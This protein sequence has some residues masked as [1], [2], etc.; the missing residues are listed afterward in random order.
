M[1]IALLTDGI[2]PHVMGGMQKHSYY[3]CKY[4]AAQGVQIDLYHTTKGTD[5]PAVHLVDFTEKERAQVRSF[6]IDYPKSDRLPGHYLRTSYQYSKRIFETMLAQDQLPDFIYAQGL[7]SWHLLR[8]RK[9]LGSIPVGVNIHGYNMYQRP[10]DIRAQLEQY[11]LRPS[12]RFI[13]RN[14]D[15]V[16]AFGGEIRDIAVNRVGVQEERIFEIPNGI[17]DDWLVSKKS[18]LVGPK[19]RR[20]TYVGRYERCKGIE[21]LSAVIE[22]LLKR[23]L[24][25]EF[26]FVGPIP[27]SLHVSHP[28]VNY[29]GK[30]VDANAVKRILRGSDVLILP[31][32]SEGMPT[33]IL[34]AMASGCAVIATDVGA[35]SV[36]VDKQVGWL[37]FPANQ[38]ALETAIGQALN[39]S[40]EELLAMKLAARERVEQRFL[41]AQVAADT[42]KAIEKALSFRP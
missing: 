37:I 33:V 40:E 2:Y 6:L 28:S 14:A 24:N 10:A 15:W 34:E 13:N 22:H 1:R 42:L 32:Y 12:F 18:I 41:W 19:V 23:S 25:F 26:H 3:L 38:T 9:Q 29:H 36:M 7:T 5:A 35:V 31:S 27:E 21:E 8:Y 30:L 11:M 39:S 17:S 4:L 16:F 20:F